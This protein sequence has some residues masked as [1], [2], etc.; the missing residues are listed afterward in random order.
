MVSHVFICTLEVAGRWYLGSWNHITGEQIRLIDLQ[1]NL[2]MLAV[3]APPIPAGY[4]ELICGIGHDRLEIDV[5]W[6][7]DG[8]AGRQNTLSG[9]RA[10]ITEITRTQAP[11]GPDLLASVAND[12]TLRI[13][14]PL[15]EQPLIKTL[16]LPGLCTKI[17]AGEPGEVYVAIDDYW[18]RLRI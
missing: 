1:G 12:Q 9:H 3:L 8:K 18:L 14:N 4:Q 11:H 17:V 16:P 10:E 2:Q 7:T 15:A 6:H 5:W 13:W